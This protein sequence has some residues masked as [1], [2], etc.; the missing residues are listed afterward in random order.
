MRPVFFN[1]V[2]NYIHWRYTSHFSLIQARV[3]GMV[4]PSDIGRIPHK[5]M[6]GFAFLTADQ[7]K[8]WWFTFQSLH[9]GKF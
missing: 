6:S 5:I 8:N 7:L 4:V 9:L 3:D 1:K 2:S